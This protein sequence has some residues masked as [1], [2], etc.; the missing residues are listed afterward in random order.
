MEEEYDVW[1]CDLTM[2]YVGLR[3][4]YDHICYAIE[5]WPGAPKRPVEEQEYL[6]HLKTQ[7]A[8]MIFQHQYDEG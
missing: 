2:D 1:T 7:L 6:L 8:A 4:L 3:L 5:V